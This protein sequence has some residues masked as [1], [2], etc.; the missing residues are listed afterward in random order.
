MSG[1]YRNTRGVVDVV[2]GV[3]AGL[4]MTLLPIWLLL[5][6]QLIFLPYQ[7]HLLTWAHR[8]FVVSDFAL[9]LWLL[10]P[11]SLRPWFIAA[12]RLLALALVLFAAATS[13]LFATFP[14]EWI[15]TMLIG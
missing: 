1:R 7:D 4:T 8:G 6:T 15:Y 11:F 14:G 3:I 2:S 12:G 9:C 5:L 10:W 13:I